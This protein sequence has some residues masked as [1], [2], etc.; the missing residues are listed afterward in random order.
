M[1]YRG[2]LRGYSVTQC[3]I[4]QWCLRGQEWCRVFL[5]MSLSMPVWFPRGNL[6]PKVPFNTTV[7]NLPNQQRSAGGRGKNKGMKFTQLMHNPLSHPICLSPAVKSSKCKSRICVLW[8]KQSW[9][10][11][12]VSEVERCVTTGVSFR[13]GKERKRG[14]SW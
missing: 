9:D 12:S 8:E 7:W 4:K 2:E 5:G 3:I 10:E 6:P 14:L 11:V 1:S 13:E